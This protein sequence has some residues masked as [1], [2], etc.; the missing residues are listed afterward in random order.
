MLCRQNSARQ[1]L[2]WR[3]KNRA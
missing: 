1:E 3:A 2:L